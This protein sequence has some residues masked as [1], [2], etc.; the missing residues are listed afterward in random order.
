MYS[1]SAK[2][3]SL[4]K[5]SIFLTLV[6]WFNPSLCHAVD[7]LEKLILDRLSA[8]KKTLDLS[9]VNIGSRGAKILAGMSF[10]S[11]VE[12]LLLQGNK[13]KFSG[14]KALSK[15]PHSANLKNLDLWGNMIGDMG[16]KML[17]ESVFIKG[18]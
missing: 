3:L 13:I 15:S 8:D 9:G 10:L 6:I 14:I 12:T 16:L 7:S 11:D 2:I 1:D 5:V 18:L 17:S 4:F